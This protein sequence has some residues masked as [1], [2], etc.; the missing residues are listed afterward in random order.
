ME[1]TSMG[2]GPR[3]GSYSP[4]VVAAG[5][6]FLSGQGGLTAEGRPVPGGIVAETRQ[7][8]QNVRSLLAQQGLDLSDVVN[9]T[10][11]LVDIDEWAA[12]DAEYASHFAGIDPLPA[13]TA[14]AVQAL[15]LGLR[16]EITCVAVLRGDSAR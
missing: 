15:P 9:V 14:L 6:A 5:L 3:L 10:C 4:G 16:V 7:A 8:M 1:H 2:E 11:Y 12:M 13:R